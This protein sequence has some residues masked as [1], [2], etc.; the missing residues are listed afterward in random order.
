M[1]QGE[2]LRG[3]YQ[4]QVLCLVFGIWAHLLFLCGCL[5]CQILHR[6]LDRKYSFICH[7]YGIEFLTV[8]VLSSFRC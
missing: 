3:V 2:Q 8:S 1:L 4:L 7:K 5:I 6:V